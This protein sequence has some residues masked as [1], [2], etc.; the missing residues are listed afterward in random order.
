MTLRALLPLAASLLVAACGGQPEAQE[1]PARPV[2]IQTVEAGGL[3]RSYEFVGRVEARRAVD[4]SFQVGG[5]LGQLPVN[6]GTDVAEGD[7]IA[8]L[9]LEEF[10]R[11]EREA[12]VQLQQ[13]RADLDRQQTLFDRGIAA[14]AALEAAQTQYD[15]RAVEL[16]TVRQNLQRATLLQIESRPH[17]FDDWL[18]AK[19]IDGLVKHIRAEQDDLRKHII[20]QGETN[21]RLRDLIEEMLREGEREREAERRR[22]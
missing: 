7:L 4:L 10:R 18:L 20:E 14:A 9:D 8:Q 3:Q 16:E 15:L 13:A 1:R 5:Q 6:D 12:N 11:A 2:P 21:R 22:G 19:G 17:A